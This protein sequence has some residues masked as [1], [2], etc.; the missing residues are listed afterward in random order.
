MI[1]IIPSESNERARYI[2]RYMS[3]ESARAVGRGRAG[4]MVRMQV[5]FHPQRLAEIII[6]ALTGSVG[7]HLIIGTQCMV[8]G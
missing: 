3:L 8:K 7:D 6:E 5:E 2:V 1:C 4:G